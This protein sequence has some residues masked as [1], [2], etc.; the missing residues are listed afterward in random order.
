V[1]DRGNGSAAPTPLNGKA[2]DGR[3]LG[4]FPNFTLFASKTVAPDQR[5]VALTNMLL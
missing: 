4:E 5:P 1:Y 2:F 3:I